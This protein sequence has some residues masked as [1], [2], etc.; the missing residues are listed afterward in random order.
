[1]LTKPVGENSI[2][3]VEQ[4]QQ[5]KK[6]K[7]TKQN[8]NAALSETIGSERDENKINSFFFLTIS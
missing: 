7:K 5:N 8:K 1:V 2:I 4:K 3:I 6:T